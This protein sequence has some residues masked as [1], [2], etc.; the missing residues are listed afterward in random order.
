[1]W[2]G[3]PHEFQFFMDHVRSLDFH[4]KPDYGLLI[5]LFNTCLARH[6][7]DANKPEFPWTARDMSV[8]RAAICPV[9]KQKSGT[10]TLEMKQTEAS[11]ELN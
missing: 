6:R 3:F 8:R 1:M 2:E 5:E 4:D 10:C 9:K 11:E 7:L